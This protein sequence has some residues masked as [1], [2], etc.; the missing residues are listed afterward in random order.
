MI[1]AEAITAVKIIRVVSRA[2][3]VF[4]TPCALDVEV[5]RV[6]RNAPSS[7][8]HRPLAPSASPKAIATSQNDAEFNMLHSSQTF[9]QR[10]RSTNRKV[11]VFLYLIYM[12]CL[13]AIPSS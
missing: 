9:R 10:R 13:S 12:R 5:E 2:E 6:K 4:D 11:I 3:T 1:I 7:D 8:I